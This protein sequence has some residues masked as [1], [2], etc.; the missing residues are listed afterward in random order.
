MRV[1]IEITR[2]A[3][4]GGPLTKQIS[5]KPDGTMLSDGSACIMSRGHAQRVRF[6]DLGGFADLI[7]SLEPHEAVALGASRSD[8][9]EHVRVTTQDRLATLNGAVPPDLIARTSSHIR[10]EAG[11]PALA[12]IDIDTKGMPPEVR[13]RIDRTGGFW[14]ALTSVLPALAA[15]GRIMRRSTS[16]GISRTDT[17]QALPGSNGMHVYLHVRD[18]ADVERFL[19]TLHERCWLAGLAW[20]MVGAGGQLL[21]R[22]LVDRMVY[23]A[24]RLVF[25]GRP[26]LMPSLVQDQASR[27]PE[28]HT[29]AALN[30]IEACPP[31]SIVETARLKSLKSGSAQAFAP[32]RAKERERFVTQHAAR[33]AERSGITSHEAHRVIEKQCEGILLPDVVSPWDDAAFTRCTVADVLADP[34]RFVGATLADPLEGSDYGRTKAMLMRR[35][36]GSLWIN[37]FAHGRTVYELRYDVRAAAAAVAA[38]PADQ[39][40]DAFVRVAV[41]ADLDA[42]QM[43]A[44]RNQVAGLA[45]VGKRALD[46]KLKA[47]RKEQAAR[48]E[49]E[50]RDQRA[51]DRRDP[52]PQIAAPAPDA[53][54]LPQMAVLNDILG[55][56]DL[57]EP[58]MRDVDG[59]VTKVRVRRMPNMHA[60]TPQGVNE[61]EAQAA[62]QPATE[63]PL[64]TRPDE[65]RLAELIEQHVDYVEEQG[66]S[67]HLAAPFV[68]HFH[69]RTDH[70]LP[71]VVAIATLPIVLP[72]GT[73]LTARGLDRQRGIVFRVPPD[74]LAL[75]PGQEECTPDE[76][77]ESMRFLTEEWLVDVATNYTGKC[78]LIAAALTVI[79]RS[80]LAERPAFFLT[81]GRRGGGKTTAL[82]MLL[83]AVTG[84]RP[85]AAAWSSNEEERRKALLSY[86]MEA[87]AAIIWDNIPRGT[88]I[89]CPHIEKSCTAAFYSDRRLGVSEMVAVSASVV[90]LFTG[91][92]IGLRGDL[93][94]RSLLVRLEVD[95]A[96]P[97][98]REFKHPDPIGWTKA[99]RPKILRALYTILLGNPVLQPSSTVAL[100][101]RFKGWWRLIGSAAEHAAKEHARDTAERVAALAM[102]APASPPV[103]VNF[104]DL[105][106]SQE[107]DDEEDASLGDALG[108]LAAKWPKA[109][110]FK[111]T[112]LATL[113]NYRGDFQSIEDKERAA[114]LRDFLFP[115]VPPNQDVSAKSV[116]RMMKSRVGEPVK[117]GDRIADSEGGRRSAFKNHDLPRA[118][119]GVSGCAAGFAGYAGFVL[120]LSRAPNTI[121]GAFSL[122]VPPGN[123]V[124][125]RVERSNKPRKPRNW[126]GQTVTPTAANAGGCG[127][128]DQPEFATAIWSDYS[129]RRPDPTHATRNGQDCLRRECP[130]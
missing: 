79:E 48:A 44:L 22:S 119:E 10:Y 86:L 65:T 83:V 115:K 105:F 108:A 41:N 63:Q 3:K 38:V 84:I 30:T 51:A 27:R 57:P 37:S 101:T 120:A 111:A 62:Q 46:A 112:D 123:N 56:S 87:L 107:Q 14:T 49:Q 66:R 54:W 103:E 100:H 113:L 52:R 61:G 109:E 18:G 114:I 4:T 6:N 118:D 67:V 39:A 72:D 32:Q 9:P 91:N 95:R 89:A 45:G 102:D 64:L 96:D 126:L 16:S 23:A 12:L 26:V 58:P 128:G 129:R 34:A 81:A 71:T 82:I 122:Y 5:L 21:D 74:L 73:L 97:E 29:G 20:H 85:S 35:A 68:R 93:T 121:C 13:V 36:D 76:V 15:V 47:A 43:E 28:V 2:L 25:E 90:H 8:L 19:R 117:A 106:L 88:Q 7:Q 17:G 33:L 94:S 50:A 70:A 75:I 59:V 11:R 69:T 60:L 77:A 53:P 80:V 125:V 99:N 130:N 127:R 98:N 42:H 116:G 31:L 124:R 40:A 110:T 55:G 92:N 78:I 1:V 24:E 104:R